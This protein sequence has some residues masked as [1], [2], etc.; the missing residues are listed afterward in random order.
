MLQ[1]IR[2]GYEYMNEGKLEEEVELD[3]TFVGGKNKNRYWGQKSKKLSR[4]KLQ[5]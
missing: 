1:R 3:E 2:L 5:R 4:T